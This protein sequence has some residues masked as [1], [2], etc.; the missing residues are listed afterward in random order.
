MKACSAYSRLGWREAAVLTVVGGGGWSP[1][2]LKQ[3][4]DR[5]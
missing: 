1:L 3:V 4:L 2:C 5:T